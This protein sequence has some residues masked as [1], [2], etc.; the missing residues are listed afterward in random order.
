MQCYDV[1]SL[2]TVQ[3]LQCSV[4]L[5]VNSDVDIQVVSVIQEPVCPSLYVGLPHTTPT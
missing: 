4:F 2:N 1:S 3:P 5:E